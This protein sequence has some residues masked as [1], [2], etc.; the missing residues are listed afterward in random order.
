MHETISIYALWL[1][2]RISVAV[3]EIEVNV[4]VPKLYNCKWGSRT[5]IKT[6]ILRYMV[7]KLE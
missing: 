4:M 5:G 2:I 3:L 6:V 1:L 7:L